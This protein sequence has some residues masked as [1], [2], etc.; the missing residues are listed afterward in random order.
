MGSREGIGRPL[1]HPHAQDNY[2]LAFW[3]R[4][5]PRG[6][7][8]GTEAASTNER[9]PPLHSL[10]V[11]PTAL[12][13]SG[14]S[15]LSALQRFPPLYTSDH[16]S[17]VHRFQ[18]IPPLYTLAVVPTSLRF[19]G[20]HRSTLQRCPPLSADSTA[21]TLP[22]VSTAHQHLNSI[23]HR[24]QWPLA[25]VS[26]ACS[27]YRQDNPFPNPRPHGAHH[28]H[29]YFRGVVR[30]PFPAKAFVATWPPRSACC[31]GVPSARRPA[32]SRVVAGFRGRHRSPQ[33][34]VPDAGRGAFTSS[35]CSCFDG[36]RRTCCPL[37]GGV[38]HA[39]A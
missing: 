34:S 15:H 31:H 36:R 2:S 11:V 38:S 35:R 22:A 18:R 24:S 29:Y 33:G 26:T 6:V 4:P 7:G 21:S 17:G 32:G 30:S 37:F 10:A 1:R 13:F 14:R 3:T 16:F 25:T 8:E 27:V 9:G 5:L 12:H 23:I 39:L 28:D 19:S 20:F